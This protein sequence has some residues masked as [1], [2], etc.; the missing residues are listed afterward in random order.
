[1]CVRHVTSDQNGNLYAVTESGE[2]LHNRHANGD[3]QEPATNK[4]PTAWVPPLSRFRD[5]LPSRPR[6]AARHRASGITASESSPNMHGCTCSARSAVLVRYRCFDG[7]TTVRHQPHPHPVP[8]DGLS[9]INQCPEWVMTTSWTLV[10]AA[11]RWARERR[12]APSPPHRAHVR[13]APG[14]QCPIGWV[15][16]SAF[17]MDVAVAEHSGWPNPLALT[18]FVMS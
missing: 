6:R 18:P 15:V 14:R 11:R 5:L 17:P 7:A 9:S 3:P 10:A 1:M 16:G 4:K 2:L 8:G 12:L 13:A